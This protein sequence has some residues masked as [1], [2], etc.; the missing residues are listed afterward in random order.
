MKQISLG[1]MGFEV[2]N[3]PT[4]KH[5]LLDR[6]NPVVS[7][8]ELVT[9]IAPYTPVAKTGRPPFAAKAMLPIH[10]LHQWFYLSD[11]AMEEA[12]YNMPLFQQFAELD[13]G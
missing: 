8:A 13:V 3:K 4:R 10:F 7:W 1:G 2:S 6:R 12:L 5:E 11:P 9:L